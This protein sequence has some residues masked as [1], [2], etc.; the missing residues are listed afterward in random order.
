MDKSRKSE[1]KYTELEVRKI[2]TWAFHFYQTNEF[3][4]S[5]LEEEFERLLE[6]FFENRQ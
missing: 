2:A 4:D 6:N 3:S 1:K 5:E